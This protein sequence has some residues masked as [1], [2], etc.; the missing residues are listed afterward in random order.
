[1][2]SKAWRIV[3]CGLCLSAGALWAHHELSAEFDDKKPVTVKGV[4]TRLEWNNP[5]AFLYVDAADARG[6]NSWAIEL[7]S[8]SE[9]RRAGWSREVFKVGETVTVDANSARD[10]GKQVW[11]KTVTLAGGKK[12]ATPPENPRPAR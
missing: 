6:V 9:L 12:L 5:H 4:I 2:K 11:G 3:T 1:M 10:G 8:P 7:P